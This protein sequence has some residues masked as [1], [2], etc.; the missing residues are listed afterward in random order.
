MR[1]NNDPVR[2]GLVDSLA[3][4]GGNVTGVAGLGTETIARRLELLKEAVPH[5]SRL[6]VLRHLTGNPA[7]LPRDVH[8]AQ[9]VAHALGVELHV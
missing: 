6:A 5:L 8:E 7:D 9:V 2:A 3:R 4:P 1:R